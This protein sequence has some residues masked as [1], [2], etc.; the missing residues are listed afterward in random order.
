MNKI[1]KAERRKTSI[2]KKVS[3]TAERPRMCVNKSLKN[4]YVQ[5]IDDVQGK[6]LCGMNTLSSAVKEKIKTVTRKNTA[7]AV[8]LG[9]GIAKLAA[10]KGIKKVVFDRAGYKY[11]GV[12]KALA[13]SARKN[14]LQF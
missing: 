7:S 11:H 1:I 3:G 8:A 6:T 13:D 9:E 5:I 12:V 10:A 4:I 14:G 2:R